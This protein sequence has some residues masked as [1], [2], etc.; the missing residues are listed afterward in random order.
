MDD[1]QLNVNDNPMQI[2]AELKSISNDIEKDSIKNLSD[3]IPYIQRLVS[4]SS[5]DIRGI[6]KQNLR[7]TI[8]G[9]KSGETGLK[10]MLLNTMNNISNNINKKSP[11]DDNIPLLDCALI[12]F[13]RLKNS[14]MN[15]IIAAILAYTLIEKS[16][17]DMLVFIKPYNNEELLLLIDDLIEE[18]VFFFFR[19]LLVGLIQKSMTYILTFGLIKYYQYLIIWCYRYLFIIK[20][21]VTTNEEYKELE[22][23]YN[24]ESTFVKSFK[25]NQ[26]KEL[27]R[28][29]T[30]DTYSKIRYNNSI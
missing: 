26:L 6:A 30:L 8:R 29:L 25:N 9:V 18:P 22:K 16:Y 12:A 21:I 2:K 13:N 11:L 27:G 3:T 10:S 1:L 5:D 20:L 28:I 24:L 15:P 7:D 4:M 19:N 17:I 14:D 23:K